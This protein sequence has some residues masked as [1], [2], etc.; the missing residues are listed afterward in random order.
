MIEVRN[1]VKQYGTHLALDNLSFNVEDNEIFG[2]LGPNGAGKSTTMN[3]ITGYLAPTSGMVAIDGHDIVE[4]PIAAKRLIGYL[5]ELP[6]VYMDMTPYEYLRFVGQAKG[7]K[8]N[9]LKAEIQRV[10]EKTS[11]V[12]VHNQL[13]KTLSKGYRQRVGMAQAILGSPKVIIMDEPT[14]GLDPV[15]IIEFREMIR[16]LGKEHTVIL[17][18]HI[19]AEISEICHKIM[20]IVKGRLVAID[21]PENLAKMIG[22]DAESMS[23]EEIFLK[24]VEKEE[25]N[26]ADDL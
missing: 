2:F 3:I 11:I 13:I 12:D 21:T 7:V 20:I 24:F 5:P 18:S 8:K 6:P 9:E 17:S 26:D 14:V 1:L 19:L 22:G 23:L 16:E 25:K 15:Q 10:M 4:E